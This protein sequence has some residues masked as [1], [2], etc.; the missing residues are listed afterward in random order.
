MSARMSTT[1]FRMD[2]D[3][4]ERTRKGLRGFFRQVFNKK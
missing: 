2:D 4:E 1:T 3:E